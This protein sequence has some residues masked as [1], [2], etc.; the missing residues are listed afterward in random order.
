M[1][2]GRIKALLEGVR[3]GAVGTDQAL[4]ELKDLP[5]RDLGFASV[6]HHRSLRTG[7]P[8]VILGEPKTADQI[9]A[10]AIEI[11][12]M[13]QNV[14][15]TRLDAE[16]A[17]AVG[18]KVPQLVYASLARTGTIEV[19]PIRP[20]PGSVAIVTA[21]TADLPVAE[22]AA[23]TLRMLGIQPIRIY[24]VGVAGI[25]RLLDRKADLDSCSGVIVVAGMEGALPSVVGGLVGKPIVGVPTSVGYGANLY[26]FTSL[27]GMLT[28]C[29]AGLSVVNIDNGFGAAM[30]MGRMLPPA[31]G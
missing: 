16:K 5:F 14:L 12:R 9:A 7:A 6:D 4:A 2:I 25:H 27:L 19:A 13:G 1:D 20:R 28:S 26:G 18:E 31:A 15:I 24:D 8:E 17:A 23:E 22:E 29:A 21:G 10:I 30:A 11:A 3:S